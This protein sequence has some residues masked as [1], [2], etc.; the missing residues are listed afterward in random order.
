MVFGKQSSKRPGH[1]RNHACDRGREPKKHSSSSKQHRPV[2]NH[3]WGAKAC[4]F[5]F[6]SSSRAWSS[7]TCSQSVLDR[8]SFQ[9]AKRRPPTP[10]VKLPFVPGTVNRAQALL[11]WV[12]IRKIVFHGSILRFY[13]SLWGSNC[14]VVGLGAEHRQ[15]A[16][17]F[18][19]MTMS[20]MTMSC[21][22]I[23][24]AQHHTDSY[25]TVCQKTPL[26]RPT[27]I[28]P[29]RRETSHVCAVFA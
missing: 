8:T 10:A 23:S 12:G 26:A 21:Q 20:C 29:S 7:P 16:A 19:S 17:N 14:F 4:W 18:S 1:P 9:V 11:P 6:D 27:S 24:G 25:N 13:V 22:G 3:A 28:L 15:T 2:E 5:D